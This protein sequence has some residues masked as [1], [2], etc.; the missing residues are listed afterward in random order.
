M[1][2]F[3]ISID[4]F[5][6]FPKTI[7][8]MPISHV[9]LVFLSSSAI[10]FHKHL[11]ACLFSNLQPL[12]SKNGKVFS[13]LSHFQSYFLA[14]NNCK[15]SFDRIMWYVLWPSDLAHISC[16]RICRICH[17]AIGICDTQLA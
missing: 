1:K 9:S 7:F 11:F 16:S 14:S 6:V 12:E 15:F 5:L 17:M 8:L 2:T 10:H 4:S 3:P 13:G